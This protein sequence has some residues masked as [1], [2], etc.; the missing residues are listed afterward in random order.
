[1]NEQLNLN[2]SVT[3]NERPV[4]KRVPVNRPAPRGEQTTIDFDRQAEDLPKQRVKRLIGCISDAL[5]LPF[6]ECYVLAYHELFKRTGFH[7]VVESARN[8][9]TTH[10]ELVE[11]RGMLGELV[12]AASTVLTSGGARR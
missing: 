12:E 5:G 11:Q 4:R 6:H 7:P 2:V 3:I 10:L 8:G 9:A 1:M